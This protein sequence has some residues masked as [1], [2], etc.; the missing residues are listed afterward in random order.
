MDI[1]IKVVGVV[2]ILMGVVNVANPL[3]ILNILKFLK[4][5]KRIYLLAI[6]R[7]ALGILFLISAREC[8][9]FWIIFCFGLLFLLSGAL[10]VIM[11]PERIRKMIEWFEKRKPFVLRILG[12]V[13]ALFGVIVLLAA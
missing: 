10:V 13:V 11:P 12:I 1:A 7:F 9:Q 6:A 3:I 2:I 4:P 5:G 8:R